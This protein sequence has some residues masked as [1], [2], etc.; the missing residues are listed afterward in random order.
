[1]FLNI[2]QKSEKNICTRVFFNKDSDW[3]PA[4]LVNNLK[5]QKKSPRGFKK[6]FL[7]ISQKSQKSISTG[8]FFNKDSDW[9]P[10][11]LLQGDSFLFL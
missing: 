10:A 5:N 7:N 6:V 8:V 1:M 9:G 3:G 4:T 11:T 2:S